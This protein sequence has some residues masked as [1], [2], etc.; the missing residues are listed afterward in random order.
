MIWNLLKDFVSLFNVGQ[1]GVF[2]IESFASWLVPISTPITSTSTKHN[3]LKLSKLTSEFHLLS[4]YLLPNMCRTGRC[5][6]NDEIVSTKYV[7]FKS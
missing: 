3:S 5:D 7:L 4:C 1:W 6:N 2:S